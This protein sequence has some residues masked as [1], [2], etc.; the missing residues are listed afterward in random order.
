M[1]IYRQTY[2][3]YEGNVRGRFRWWVTVEQELRVLSKTRTFLVLLII[4]YLHVCLRALQ[5]V[6]YD[7]LNASPNNPVVQALRNV[8][9]FS[10]N[11][12]MFFDFL[13][14]QSSLVFLA[15]ILAGAGMI[16]NDYRNNLMEIYFAKPM[17]WRDYAVGKI[18]A[19]VLVG[20][21]FTALP[22]IVLVL[23]HNVLSPGL[24]TV[25]ATYWLAGSILAFSLILGAPCALGVLASSALSKSQRYASIGVFMLLFGNLM[26]GQLLPELLHQR[27]YAIVA[28]P[29]AINRIGES[30]FAQRHPLF[31][32]SWEWS[33][34]YVAAV[35]GVCLW[36]VCRK[37][38][39]AEIG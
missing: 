32:L 17:T 19:L 26:I 15:T 8:A 39:C 21:G 16:C 7:T 28:F 12:T 2:R 9:L 35:C 10:V 13:R 34:L 11:E 25:Q 31:E 20:L 33:G 5:V 38:R 1:P 36:I 18:M 27:D 3:T 22:G 6:A 23:L 14:M 4:G 30:L 37:V 24:A 29:L